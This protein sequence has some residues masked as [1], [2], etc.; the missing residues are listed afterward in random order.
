MILICRRRHLLAIAGFAAFS[1]AILLL[2]VQNAK[3][4]TAFS[5]RSSGG[6]VVIIDAG[7]GGEDGGAVSADGI[8]ESHI[9]LAIAKRAESLL[10]FLGQ[11]TLM[12]RTGE[13][14]V[15][16]DDA[17][18]LREKK[19]SDLKNRVA[20]INE[21]K[22]AVL[23]SIHQNS[24]P[25]HPNVHG[26][27]VFYNTIA[28][29]QK[30]AESVQLVLNEQINS[31]NEKAAKPIDGSVYLM[32]NSQAPSILMECGFMSNGNEVQLLQQTDYQ[33]RLAACIVAGF[34]QYHVNEG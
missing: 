26:A 13:E 21:Q 23:L 17:A 7:H 18:T 28:P 9:N 11:E 16:S 1:L 25:A 34:R 12:T 31:G 15:Y 27:Q 22:E 32:K 29:G 5:P 30:M 20:M 6:R 10:L 24:L 14:A 8:P 3:S 4:T 33:L 2:T 19:V